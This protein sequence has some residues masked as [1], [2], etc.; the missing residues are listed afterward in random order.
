MRRS[1]FLGVSLAAATAALVVGGPPIRAE[2]PD[3][4]ARDLVPAQKPLYELGLAPEP[5]LALE[6]WVDSPERLYAVGQQLK[7]FVRP[8]ETSYITVLNVG[9]SGRVAVIFPNFH[10]RNMQ[11]RGGQTVAIP[12][13]DAGWRI[14]VAGPP[15]IEVIKIIASPEP[16][17]LPEIIELT[18]ATPER[19]LVSLGRSGTEVARDLVPQ[20]AAPSGIPGL[21]SRRV[22]NL[23]LRVVN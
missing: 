15:G 10:Q 2:T 17:R 8:S 21:A 20:V 1:R 11:V 9:S 5:E 3:Q 7:V 13:D 19:P 14:D 4:M 12:A 6:A 16:L 22:K 18:N 23:L